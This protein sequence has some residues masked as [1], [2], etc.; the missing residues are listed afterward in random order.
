M[1][2]SFVLVPVVVVGIVD[3]LRGSEQK[4][5]EHR[6]AKLRCEN[7]PHFRHYTAGLRRGR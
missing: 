3:V 5:L 1:N 2:D 6:K 4:G 7:R